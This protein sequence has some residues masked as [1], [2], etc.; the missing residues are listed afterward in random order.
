MVPDRGRPKTKT[1]SPSIESAAG[2]PGEEGGL[3]NGDH[4]RNEALVLVGLKCVMTALQIGQGQ[5]I[6]DIQA[7]GRLVVLFSGI[8]HL[9]QSKQQGRATDVVQS[10][11]REPPSEQGE[12]IVRQI[13]AQQDRQAR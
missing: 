6:G 8:E 7:V 3:K 13:A 10:P 2:E 4:V 1:G 9:G 11:I 12:V 5:G